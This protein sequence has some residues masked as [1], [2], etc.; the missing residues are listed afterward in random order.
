MIDNLE[1]IKKRIIYRSYHRGCK[2]LDYILSKFAKS[3]IAN[4]TSQD[5]KIYEE[6]LEIG[7]NDIFDMIKSSSV[8]EEYVGTIIEE[9]IAFYSIQLV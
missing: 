5:C 4:M 9:L 3:K 2:E 7:D 8:P 6:F 1:I